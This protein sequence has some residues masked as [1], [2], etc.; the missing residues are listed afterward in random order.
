MT[1]L[2]F[3]VAA[4]SGAGKS[5]LVNAVLA[6]GRGCGLSTR[7]AFWLALA[8]ALSPPAIYFEHLLSL[9]HI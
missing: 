6:L 7:A 4:P 2:L 9:I 8:F 3:I 1:G 5:S